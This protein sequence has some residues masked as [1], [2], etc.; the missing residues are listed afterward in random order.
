MASIKVPDELKQDVPQSSWGKIIIATPVVMTVVAT[1]LAGLAN[2]EMTKAQY[3]RSLGAQMQS[4]AGDQWGFFQAKRLRSSLQVSTLEIIGA[5]VSSASFDA[6]RLQQVVEQLPTDEASEAQRKPLL[7]L[8][9]SPEGK[10]ALHCLATSSVPALSTSFKPSENVHAVQQMLEKDEE[11]PE[12][13]ARVSKLSDTD[14]AADLAAARAQVRSFDEL[15]KPV[16]QALAKLAT[17]LQALRADGLDGGQALAFST[18]KLRYEAQRYETE[19]RLNQQV[20]GML[21]LQVRK[22]NISSERHHRRSQRFFLGMLGAQFGAIASTFAIATQKR[23]LLWGLA[24]AA[25]VL[26]LSMAGYVYLFV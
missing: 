13:N 18:A 24:A 9:N 6:T 23:N 15:T 20:A 2:S 22:A 19:A 21:E 4:K 25:G 7:A 8:L 1:M 16:N 11:T 10:T 17:A 26:S 14:L 5:T 12:T 3:E